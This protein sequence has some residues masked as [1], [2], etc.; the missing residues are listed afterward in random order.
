MV[1]GDNNLGVKNVNKRERTDFVKF[2][3]KFWI[4]CIPE[5]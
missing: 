4:I 5:T 2:N 1:E 3:S